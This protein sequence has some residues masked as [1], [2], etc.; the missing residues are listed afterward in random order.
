[1]KA[2]AEM[3]KDYLSAKGIEKTNFLHE[4]CKTYLYKT[5]ESAIG[6]CGHCGA[7]IGIPPQP[8]RLNSLKGQDG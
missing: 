5:S 8:E 1:M 7:L 3:N 6:Q 4:E 2:K